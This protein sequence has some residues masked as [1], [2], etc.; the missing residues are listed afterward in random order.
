MQ[1]RH[2][3]LG[4][5]LTGSGVLGEYVEDHRLAVHHVAVEGAL[6][7]A[8]LSRREAVVEH[9][10]VDVEALRD[11]RQLVDLPLADEGCRVGGVALHQHDVDRIGA[12]GLGEPGQLLERGFGFFGVGIAQG[13][14]DEE[15]PLAKDIDVGDG[16][17]ETA[18]LAGI[19]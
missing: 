11:R 17:G 10:N 5:A 1:Q 12:R 7:V 16:R 4:H 3:D 9:D 2:L 15:G 8:L 6:Q 18:A 13:H 19:A 14:P